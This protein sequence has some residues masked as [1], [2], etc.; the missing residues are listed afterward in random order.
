MALLGVSRGLPGGDLSFD[1]RHV[2]VEFFQTHF[3]VPVEA[4]MPRS[5]TMKPISLLSARR[6]SPIR[7]CSC[8]I[9]P[10]RR[11]MCPIR[12]YS[13]PGKTKASPTIRLWREIS[14]ATKG[15]ADPQPLLAPPDPVP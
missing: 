4:L 11:L 14:E 8:G 5:G 9:G 10:R 2:C 7:T 13:M 1:G 15:L 3:W 12:Q 6:F